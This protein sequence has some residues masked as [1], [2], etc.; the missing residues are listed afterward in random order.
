MKAYILFIA[1]ECKLDIGHAFP[2]IPANEGEELFEFAAPVDD[3][4]TMM[5]VLSVPTRF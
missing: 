2:H 1:R 4:G 5:S 3:K